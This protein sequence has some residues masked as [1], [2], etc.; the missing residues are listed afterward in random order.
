MLFNNT[1]LQKDIILSYELLIV[2]YR[3]VLRHDFRSAIV[4][5]ATALEK[6]ILHRIRKYYIVNNLSTFEQ[7]KEKHRMLGRAFGWLNELGIVIPV[8]NY[9]TEILDVR[10]PT[11]H[12][13]KIHDFSDTKK[14]LE[15]CKVIIQEYC[16]DVLE[17]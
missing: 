17:E 16:P 3:A 10:N 6:A 7:D 1:G 15:H 5:A 12:E 2:A 8:Q 4:I 11:A 13:G 14:Y 9:Q